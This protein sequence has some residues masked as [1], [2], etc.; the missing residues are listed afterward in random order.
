M[1]I[2]T[3]QNPLS[4][5]SSHGLT[6]V[7]NYRRRDDENLQN[8]NRPHTYAGE[9]EQLL[10]RNFIVFCCFFSIAHGTVDAVVAFAGAEL[11]T[12][13]GAQGGFILYIFYTIS[14]LL[15]AKPFVA[16][17]KAKLGVV[18]GLSGL[19]CY[20]VSFFLAVISPANANGLFSVGAAVGGVGAG[21]LWTS[22]GV[23]Y[24][25]NAAEYSHK[26]SKSNAKVVTN[27]AAIFSAFYLSMETIFKVV[28][29]AVFLG[30]G[31]RGSWRF[32]VFALYA[33]AAF[34][35]V[36][37][38]STLT[39]PLTESKDQNG[40]SISTTNIVSSFS[41]SKVPVKQVKEDVSAVMRIMVTIPKLQLL[42]PYQVCFGF[43]SGLVG[44]YVNGVIVGDYLGD[45]YLGLLSGIATFAAVSLA[46]PY[47]Y[48]SNNL[49][50]GKW[51]IMIF[52]GCCFAFAGFPMLVMSD[53]QMSSWGFLVIYFIIHGAARGV[54]ENTNKSL[55]VDYFSDTSERE[56]AFAAVYFSS[57]FS[58]ALGYLFSLYLSRDA[59]AGL[60]FS[61]A[62]IAT[63]AYHWSFLRNR[64]EQ[65]HLPVSNRSSPSSSNIELN[66]QD[67]STN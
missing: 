47:A 44:I 26:R 40:R 10:L 12:G 63:L 61:V 16:V 45:G 1:I 33:V 19:L 46:I 39:I 22:Q 17:F 2:A 11:G 60:N 59:L 43:A 42:L 41:F 20:V 24:S 64:D 3:A 32:A 57:G 66:S 28:A 62:V 48:L 27:F 29:T 56:A 18:V 13:L 58:G 25:L 50:D 30:E 65:A 67:G 35:A 34:T 5:D 23:Y 38:V 55:I 51:Y 9:S 4:E 37:A 36:V 6:A 54:W 21:I 14:A 8:D 7:T 31:G 15:I 49:K 52:G 53:Q